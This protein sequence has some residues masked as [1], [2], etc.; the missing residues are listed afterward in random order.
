MTGAN[1]SC[2]RENGFGQQ[3]IFPPECVDRQG[4]EGAVERHAADPEAS[5]RRDEGGSAVGHELSRG[6][7]FEHQVGGAEISDRDKLRDIWFDACR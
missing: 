1:G 2:H 7:A 4:C 3:V 5:H 6:D